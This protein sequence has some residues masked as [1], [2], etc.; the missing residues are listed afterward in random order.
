[1]KAERRH[2]LQE[3]SLVRGIRS[4]PEY[5]RAHGSKVALGLILVLLTVVLVR[6]WATNRAEGK[7]RLAEGLTTG[8]ALLERL[9]REPETAPRPS[10]MDFRMPPPAVAPERVVELRRQTWQGIDVAVAQVLAD[11]TDPVQQ[12]EAKM[13][14]AD[15]NYH[16][17]LLASLGDLPAAATR[18]S[19]KLDYSA[20]EYFKRAGEN[21]NDLIAQAASLRPGQVSAA[22]LGLA[23]VAEC[24]RD[25]AKARQ[26]YEDVSR[27]AEVSANVPDEL[28]R[29][30]AQDRLK[31][32]AT[33][34]T[35]VLVGPPQTR[36][37]FA[38][39]PAAS[40]PGAGATQAASTQAATSPAT[41]NPFVEPTTVPAT[42][43]TTI[44][45]APAVAP[46]TVPA[47]PTT[48]S[49]AT[50]PSGS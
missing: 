26:L 50:R 38:I 28:S 37:T 3:N 11:S 21:Y 42:Q 48:A 44:P 49:A 13:L 35:D 34:R 46:T 2:E 23:A 22:K 31:F 15:A 8:R 18:P 47:P 20:A 24:G 27:T 45:A 4:F 41:T 17:G 33:A 1:M 5:W 6:M 10:P 29:A 39:P 43:P 12:A 30:T 9:R 14:R 16:F 40:R 36:P 19:F 32:L 25:F 7:R